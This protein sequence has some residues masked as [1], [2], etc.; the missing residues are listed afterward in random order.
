MTRLDAFLDLFLATAAFSFVLISTFA[1]FQ[2]GSPSEIG[3]AL[4]LALFCAY[5]AGGFVL[6]FLDS[7]RRGELKM[8]TLR[9]PYAILFMPFLA[10]ALPMV[11]ILYWLV[12]PYLKG[13]FL[14]PF[15][16]LSRVM[17]LFGR[18]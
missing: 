13:A 3:L 7:L 4:K 16:F 11:L 15:L 18:S 2:A 17:T 6:A 9:S 14:G 12:I 1:V 5:L 10:V 8:P